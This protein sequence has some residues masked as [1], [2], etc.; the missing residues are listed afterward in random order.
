MHR[1]WTSVI[2]VLLLACLVAIGL[3]SGRFVVYLT[4]RVMILAIFALGY[5]LLLGRTGLL[6]FGHAAFYAGGAYGL[7]LFSLHINT[8]PLLGILVG[9]AFACLLAVVIGFFCVRHTEIYFAMLTLAFGMMV[10]S[11]IWNMREVTGGDDGLVGIVR[12]P[13][14][15]GFVSIPLV[16]TDQF[17]FFVL[18]CFL[19]TVVLV[20]LIRQSPFGMI[21][22]GI[23][24]NDRRVEFAGISIRNY[25]LAVFVISGI[26]AGLAGALGA[27]LESNTDP[28]SAHWSHSSEPVLV[29]LIGGIQTFTGP[30]VGSAIFIVLR[31]I[32]ERF[33]QNWMLWFGIILLIIIMGLRGGVVGGI[34]QLFHK[35][36]SN[37][38]ISGGDR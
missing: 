19:L 23:R 17:Y 9:V 6:S 2:I 4:M 20:Y 11:L 28:F 15:L 30:L 34:S 24:E 8:N 36:G 38:L 12:A 5:N 16:K 1:Y 26:F 25:R 33:T 37:V 31:E 35:R 27:L 14:S 21:L 13:I 22:S 18:F 3:F 29:S 7:G 32:I 10:F